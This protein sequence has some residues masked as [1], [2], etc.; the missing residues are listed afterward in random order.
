MD[1]DSNVWQCASH[2]I[3]RSCLRV[4]LQVTVKVC[5]TC[6]NGDGNFDGLFNGSV[7]RPLQSHFKMLYAIVRYYYIV[8]HVRYYNLKRVFHFSSIQQPRIFTLIPPEIFHTCKSFT[9]VYAAFVGRS[10]HCL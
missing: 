8:I 7:N 6:L 4:T 9:L 1:A 5:L 10:I 2:H 3:L